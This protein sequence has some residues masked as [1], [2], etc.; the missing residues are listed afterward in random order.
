MAF[1]PVLHPSV[2]E[3][4]EPRMSAT[5]L[6]EYLILRPNGQQNILH[7]CKFS[8]PPIVTANGDAMRALRAYNQDPR[9]PQ[10]M[11]LRVKDALTAR[12]IG[13]G[14]KP[15]TRDEALRC[16][17]IIELFERNENGLGLRSMALSEPP[18]FQMIEIEGVMLSIHPDV[19]VSGGRG[20]VGA[21]ILRVAKAPDPDACKL[22]ETRTRRGD[23]RREMARY[24]VAMLQRL[25]EAQDGKLGIPDR[26]LCFVADVRLG[27]RI[28]PAPDHTIRL[29][30]IHGACAQI[31]A[32]WPSIEP[33]PTLWKR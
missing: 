28:G 32:L 19:L 27:E 29:R 4:H 1:S 16:I 23:Q 30:D 2:T 7:D 13:V 10:D 22:P 9:R 26:N 20:R 21:G 15:K 24:M 3:R 25:L 31:S 17:E 8:R 6:A 18:K 11:L 5:A 14:V 33:K 12:A